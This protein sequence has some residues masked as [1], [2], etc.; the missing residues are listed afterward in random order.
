ML[1]LTIV[2]IF[3]IV[4]Y[5]LP[6]FLASLALLFYAGA[7][8]A[9]FKALPVTLTLAGTESR[10]LLNNANLIGAYMVTQSGA[11]PADQL[12]AVPPLRDAGGRA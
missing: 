1:G 5:R 10:A 4:Y 7:V 8:F 12:P 2:V 9:V 6:G 3:M 11:V